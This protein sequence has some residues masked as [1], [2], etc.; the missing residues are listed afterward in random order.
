MRGRLLFASTITIGVLVAFV[1]FVVLLASFAAGLISGAAMIILTIIIS[2]ISWLVSPWFTDLIHKWV[3]KFRV[4]EFEELEKRCP[5]A[6][7]LLTESCERHGIKVPMLRILD[8][9]NPTAY[10]YGSFPSNSRIVVSE[11]LFHYLTG[12]ETAAVYGH[13][14]G[15]IKNLDFIV[16]TVANTLLMILYEIYIIFTRMRSRGRNN[17]LPLIGLISLVFWWIGT[18]VVLY[19]SRTREYMADHFSGV[20]T[21]N[22]SA[23]A[24][25]LV[26]IGYGIAAEPDTPLSSRLMGSVRALN[27]IDHKGADTLG[28]AVKLSADETKPASGKVP[29]FDT[30]RV[31]KIFLFDIFNPWA[32]IVQLGSTHPLTGKRIRA[33]MDLA[34]DMNLPRI[35]N[36]DQI[37]I[38]GQALDKTRL[39]GKFFFEVLVYFGP[40]IGIVAGILLALADVRLIGMIVLTWGLGLLAKGIYRFPSIKNPQPATVLELMSDPY[41]SPLRGKPVIVGGTVVGRAAAGSLFGE[42]MMIHDPSGGLITLNYESPIPLLGNLFFGYKRTRDM[43]SHRVEATGWFRRKVSQLIDLKTVKTSERSF[44]SYTRFWALVLGVII[45]VVGIF[46]AMAAYAALSA[47]GMAGGQGVH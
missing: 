37:A 8:D 11:G 23:L 5:Q 18:Y 3:Y 39:Y 26:K 43:I 40:I 2:I 7:R 30:G 24:T 12:E 33:L 42:D 35:F 47:P 41:A 36:F 14:L 10:C 45:T 31:S 28:A 25:A 44:R 13:E 17:P 34:E 46:V 6:A 19:L 20:E 1:F 4:M 32:F 27:I 22:P 9:M 21:K 16:M 15:H 29:A 38:D